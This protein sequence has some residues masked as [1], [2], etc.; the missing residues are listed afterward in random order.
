MLVTTIRVSYLLRRAKLKCGGMRWTSSTTTMQLK[1]PS[2][3]TYVANWRPQ[4][5]GR[6]WNEATERVLR[7]LVNSWKKVRKAG[8]SQSELLKACRWEDDVLLIVCGSGE[9]CQMRQI[10]Q[11]SVWSENSLATFRRVH[12]YVNGT[13]QRRTIPNFQN[14]EIWREQRKGSPLTIQEANW[15][16]GRGCKTNKTIISELY[17]VV[18]LD[19]E[20]CIRTDASRAKL[21]RSRNTAPGPDGM[22]Y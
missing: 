21:K 14:T 3:R 20:H 16:E 18:V 17:E 11:K 7:Q 2:V 8:R 10:L 9:V 6:I 5:K 1:T 15:S 4:L 13:T 22:R 12:Q 19:D